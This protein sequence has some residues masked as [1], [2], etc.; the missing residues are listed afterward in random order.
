M[1]LRFFIKISLK[2]LVVLRIK[3]MRHEESQGVTQSHCL[4]SMYK[5][6]KEYLLKNKNK[7]Y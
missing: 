7:F 4:G 1:V 5:I 3:S 2:V 6:N